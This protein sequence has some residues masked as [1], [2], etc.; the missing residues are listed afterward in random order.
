MAYRRDAI[1]WQHSGT[2]HQLDLWRITREAMT[3]AD[4]ED[5]ISCLLG[6][7]VPDL[8]HRQEPRPHP[9]TRHGRPVDVLQRG[10]GVEVWECGLAHLGVLAGAGLDG[11]SGLALGMGL[12]RML[13]L[14][15]GERTRERC[16]ARGR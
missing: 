5:M 12:D 3:D 16:L 4:L 7:L 14:I 8:P 6:A 11:R 9:Y 15:K 13:M 10:R 2:P 1:D